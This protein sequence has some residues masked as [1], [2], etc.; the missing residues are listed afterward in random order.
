MSIKKN[1]TVSCPS[2]GKKSE[3]TVWD[4]INTAVD[5]DMEA[6]VRDRSAFLF[7][8]SECGEETYFDYGFLYHN[9]TS[10]LMIQYADTDEAAEEFVNSL[11]ESFNTEMF[12]D[13]ANN[14]YTVRVVRSRNRLIEKL[15]IFDKG[16]D[17]RMIEIYKFIVLLRYQQDKEECE[18][19]EMYFF[20][21]DKGKMAIFIYEAGEFI[22][23]SQFSEEVYNDL[24]L[25]YADKLPEF[26][27]GEMFVDEN[28]AYNFLT[29]NVDENEQQ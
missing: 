21:D 23:S 27:K 16:L 2:C 15:L 10:K 14:D 22:C 29:G 5:P 18:D 4:S 9:M 28:W 12:K 1:V 7:H 26:H 20:S 19:P 25:K 6:K 24:S 3:F 17:D 8:C 11:N 13:L